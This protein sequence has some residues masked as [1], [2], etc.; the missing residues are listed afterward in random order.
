MARLRQLEKALGRIFKA[1][2]PKKPDTLRRQR[3]EARTL[4]AAHDIEIE[5]FREGGMN[6]W[7]PKT[8]DDARDPFDG[9]HYAADWAEALSMLKQYAALTAPTTK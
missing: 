2:T 3:E 5:K 6:V 9:D 7:P 4:A 1:P 8:L